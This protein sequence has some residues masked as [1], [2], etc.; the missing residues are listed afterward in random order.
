MNWGAAVTYF[1]AGINGTGPAPHWMAE[2]NVLGFKVSVEDTFDSK[3]LHGLSNLL[4]EYADS[5]LTQCALSCKT[6]WP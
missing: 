2:Q 6:K 4:Q 1:N 5:V 3:D